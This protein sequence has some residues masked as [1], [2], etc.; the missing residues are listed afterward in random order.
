MYYF[1][2]TVHV[3]FCISQTCIAFAFDT[4]GNTCWINDAADVTERTDGEATYT[5]YRRETNQNPAYPNCDP[6]AS[7][8]PRKTL[9]VFSFKS[10]KYLLGDDC[11]N[12]ND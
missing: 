2:P 3:K 9:S 1:L 8:L 11:G 10:L 12:D 7:T 5:T 6:N 4:N